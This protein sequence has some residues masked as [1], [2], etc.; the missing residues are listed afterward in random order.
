VNAPETQQP[1]VL[2][3]KLLS[4]DSGDAV[5]GDGQRARLIDIQHR[6]SKRY[7]FPY[8]DLIWLEFEPSK[9]LVLHFSSHTVR[10]EGRNLRVLYDQL[11]RLEVTRIEGVSE[12]NDT[13]EPD[14]LCVHEVT[15]TT[16]G[17]GSA[18]VLEGL[19]PEP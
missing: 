9:D 1:A 16:S 10:V 4:S 12:R 6:R 15:V 14:E 5:R 11:L 17:D 18:D 8:T 13:G 3:E 19:V 7:G 2:L